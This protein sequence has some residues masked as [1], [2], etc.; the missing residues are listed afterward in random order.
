M[1]QR[2]GASVAAVLWA[3]A[4]AALVLAAVLGESDARGVVSL[5]AVGHGLTALALGLARISHQYLESGCLVC[6]RWNCDNPLRQRPKAARWTHSVTQPT[7][8]FPCS[9]PAKSS[10]TSTAATSPPTAAPCCSER[11]SSSP[12]SSDS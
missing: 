10:P 3:V 4:F 2:S 1:A 8:T 9:E 7:S 12:P 5:A 6:H 11:S